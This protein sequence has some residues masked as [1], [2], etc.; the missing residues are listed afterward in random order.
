MVSWYWLLA[1]FMLGGSFGFLALGLAIG[2]G[3]HGH[4]N[5]DYSRAVGLKTGAR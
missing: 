2:S 5:H 4:F 3:R 1:A